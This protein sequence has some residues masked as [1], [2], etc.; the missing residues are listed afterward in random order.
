M[1]SLGGPEREPLLPTS[2][3]RTEHL[4]ATTPIPSRTPSPNLS[5]QAPDRSRTPRPYPPT[6]V[7]PSPDE[8]GTDADDEMPRKLPAPPRRAGK[9]TAEFMG[10]KTRLSIELGLIVGLVL[11]V[12]VLGSINAENGLEGALKVSWPEDAKLV[13]PWGG[14]LVGGWIWAA[15]KRRWR[16]GVS[17]D[18]AEW[19]YPAV[20]PVLMAAQ[21]DRGMVS[22]NLVLSLGSLPVGWRDWYVGMFVARD[23]DKEGWW[24][25]SLQGAL[26]EALTW[27]LTPSLSRTEIR[28]MTIGL[29]DLLWYSE[30]PHMVVLKAALWVGGLSTWVLLEDVLRWGVQIARVPKHRFKRIATA[31]RAAT[32][33]RAGSIGSTTE[34]EEASNPGTINFTVG[35]AGVP[36]IP[37]QI[38]IASSSAAAEAIPLTKVRRRASTLNATTSYWRDL[39]YEQAQRRKIIYSLIVYSTIIL[40]S[41]V[42]FL[43]YVSY[44]AFGG[45]ALPL[46]MA[47]Y[48]F[49]GQPIYGTVL[50]HMPLISNSTVALHGS[51]Q[52]LADAPSLTAA[53]PESANTRL[54]ISLYWFIILAIGVT[55]NLVLKPYIALDT[56]R[57]IFHLTI[58]AILLPTTH[59]DPQFASL[60]LAFL[61][62]VFL[63]TDLVRASTLPP[64]SKPIA[65]FLAPFVD[66]RDLRGPVVVS[67]V[68]LLLGCAVPLWL[69]LS[70]NTN[71][72]ESLRRRLV[73]G[74][75]CVGIGDAMASLTGKRW[76]H[77]AARWPWGGGKTVIGSLGF[78]GGVFVG[79]LLAGGEMGAWTLAKL[80]VLSVAGGMWEAV[81]RGGNDNL[82]VP[83]V[84]WLGVGCLAV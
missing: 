54:L 72:S 45:H 27:L 2:E 4:D 35:G 11:G 75:V 52:V 65:E 49:C 26:G 76:G 83:V 28:L 79:F 55:L 66:G 16:G 61:L 30:R 20:V 7:S 41:L 22:G 37:I 38:P 14:L 18:I 47:T 44:Y 29:V 77:K 67:H 63:L 59:F 74:I 73:A 10:N 25:W 57:K 31:V 3:S 69:S 24:I 60:A 40:V 78:I 53:T 12:G 46:F 21:I 15:W 71:N 39:T 50:S 13:A 81:V 84:V 23:W 6:R 17:G 58:V 19:V 70:A 36:K 68:F 62:P 42:G 34:E 32:R 1:A 9:N 82:V 5:I 8:G 43:P 64:F 80:A 33:L 51:C 48:L 56:R